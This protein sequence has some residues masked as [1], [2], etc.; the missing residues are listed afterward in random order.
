VF[1]AV[2]GRTLVYCNR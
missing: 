1:I 2:I